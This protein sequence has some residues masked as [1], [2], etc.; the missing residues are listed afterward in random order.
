M[1]TAMGL[2]GPCN[3]MAEPKPYRWRGQPIPA[4]AMPP[5]RTGRQREPTDAQRT[6]DARLALLATM[7]LASTGHPGPGEVTLEEA[8]RRLGVKERT[9]LRYQRALRTAGAS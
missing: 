5:P 1:I 9:I 6:R 4:P 2:G 3:G 8:A 7:R